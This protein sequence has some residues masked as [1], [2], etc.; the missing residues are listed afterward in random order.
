MILMFDI[1]VRLQRLI[2]FLNLSSF[3][4]VFEKKDNIKDCNLM[5]TFWV[6]YPV[7]TVTYSNL[8]TCLGS[9]P[10]AKRAS[11]CVRGMSYSFVQIVTRKPSLFSYIMNEN[12]ASF[13]NYFVSLPRSPSLAE[14]SI[15]MMW[16]QVPVFLCPKN[17]QTKKPRVIYYSLMQELTNKGPVSMVRG[18]FRTQACTHPCVLKFRLCCFSLHSGVLC[19][20]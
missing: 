15:C 3:V 11:V 4:P 17:M 8:Q 2:T 14:C 20:W 1:V 6:K 16:C 10:T 5:V 13:A 9:S 7:T 18:F 19:S 12:G